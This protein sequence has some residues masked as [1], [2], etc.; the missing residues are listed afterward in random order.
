[1]TLVR[2]LT[3]AKLAERF[4]VEV[5]VKIEADASGLGHDDLDRTDR[6]HIVRIVREAIVNAI[7]HGG[8]R[9]IEIVFDC[10]GGDL[11]LRVSDD[12]RASSSPRFGRRPDLA[13]PRCAR[14]RRRWAAG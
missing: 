13:C 11:L 4:G 2:S 1:V 14:A 5:K 7:R 9:R 8:T 3:V 12:G 10:R 6:E